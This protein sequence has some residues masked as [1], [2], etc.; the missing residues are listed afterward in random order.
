MTKPLVVFPDAER[1]VVELL[2]DE[3][4]GDELVVVDDFE[5]GV[6]VGVGVPDGWT[7]E[8]SPPHLE[9][10]WD[11]TPLEAH[12]VV[13]FATI[14]VVARAASTTVAKRLAALAQGLLLAHRGGSGIAGCSPLT[15]VLPSRDPDTRAELAAIT[16]RVKV[17]ASTPVPSS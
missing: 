16:V 9:V 17:R 2:E 5:P 1:L 7:P 3:G 8:G 10:A 6:T 15:G 12:P 11:G 14:R 4:V 13:A